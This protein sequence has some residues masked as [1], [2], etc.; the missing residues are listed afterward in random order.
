MEAASLNDPATPPMV[1]DPTG[2]T[3]TPAVA[4]AGVSVTTHYANSIG[5]APSNVSVSLDSAVTSSD[6]A[7]VSSFAAH[8]ESHVGADSTVAGQFSDSAAKSFFF[9]M[10][11]VSEPSLYQF[12]GFVASNTTTGAPTLN[13]QAKLYELGGP[14]LYQTSSLNETI[15]QV[16]YFDPHA[17]YILTGWTDLS[18]T[19]SGIGSEEG[20]AS[21][22]VTL[23]LLSVPEPA[24]TGAILGASL[25][26]FAVYRRTQTKRQEHLQD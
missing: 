16:G 22:Y 26:G 12:S 17:T 15:S 14:T 13:N 20:D 8:G 5:L 19:T 9:Y 23:S 4:F 24:E 6:L 2:L 25:V 18:A 1:S 21:Y 11:Q 7:G 10:F 3:P